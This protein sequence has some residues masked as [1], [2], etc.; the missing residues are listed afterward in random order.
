[1]LE[2][3]IRETENKNT[4]PDHAPPEKASECW[5]RRRLCR[6]WARNDYTYPG[7][8]RYYLIEREYQGILE[9]NIAVG[10]TEEDVKTG[11]VVV[12]HRGASTRRV[13]WR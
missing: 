8:I 4:L 13:D 12:C 5:V 6:R 9:E 11:F 1:M 10:P 3:E 7:S 2:R